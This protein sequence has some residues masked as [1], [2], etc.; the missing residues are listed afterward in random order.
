[1]R[2]LL[3]GLVFKT[4][5]PWL[6]ECRYKLPEDGSR[7]SFVLT[8]WAFGFLSASAEDHADSHSH[9]GVCLHK[10]TVQD[11][12]HIMEHLE[13]I[14]EKN[15]SE[16]SPQVLQLHYFKMHDYNGDN[17]LDDLE[18]TTVISHVHKEEEGEHLNI[19][20]R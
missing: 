2:C 12:E 16:M 4:A 1:M 15:E 7:H 9:V 6:T 8:S 10:N 5:G 13:V 20:T 18:L 14:I 11:K 19:R 17:L 3:V